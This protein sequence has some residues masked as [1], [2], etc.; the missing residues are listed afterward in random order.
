MKV[1]NQVC[2]TSLPVLRGSHPGHALFNPM[3]RWMKVALCFAFCL[4]PRSVLSKGAHH[5]ASHDAAHLELIWTKEI[6]RV[7]ACL[8]ACLLRGD[9]D[10]LV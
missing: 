6:V 1:R 3:V 5:P 7:F 10:S 4:A 9:E 8:P 2:V